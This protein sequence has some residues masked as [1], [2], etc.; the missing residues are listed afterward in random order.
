M[1]STFT[2]DSYAFRAHKPA[3]NWIGGEWVPTH[4]QRSLA[5]INPR[6][7]QPMSHVSLSDSEDV[8]AAVQAGQEAFASWK[9]VPIRERAAVF[10]RLKELLI[11]ERKALAWLVSH[12]NG[13]TYEESL[14]SVDKAIECVEFGCSL[15]NLAAGHELTVSR[16]ITCTETFEPLGVVAGITPFNFPLMVPLWML[17]QAIIGGNTFVLKPSEQVPLSVMHLA[18]LLAEAGLPPGVFNI[19]QGDSEAATALCDHPDIKALAFVGSTKVAKF[20]YGR[21]ASHG[22]PVLCLGGA[23]N[24]LIVVPDADVEL[25]ADNIVASFTGC[26]GQRCMAASVLV[27]VGDVDPIIDAVIARARAL[28]VGRDMGT[29]IHQASL[30]RIC[31]LI[32]QAESLGATVRLDGRVG[33]PAEGFWLGPTILDHLE[34][35]APALTEEIFGPVLSIVRVDTLEQAL[36]LENGSSYGNGFAI[37]T[38]SGNTAQHALSSAEAGMCGVN[39]GVPVPREPFGFGGWNQSKFGHGDITGWDG[40]RFWTRPR[41]VTTKWALQT[42]QTWMS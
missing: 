40:F 34:P 32:Q 13:K 39:V 28:E 27:A 25:S 18:E 7:A 5:V 16:G 3:N 4:T 12:E 41:K 19:V 22:K 8:D 1:N 29:I 26:A 10:Y 15:P 21:A 30:E 11:R 31:S 24:H 42:D 38:N 2:P 20:L 9:D 17:P 35:G 33:M 6:H 37:Y 36:S 14:G 23:K